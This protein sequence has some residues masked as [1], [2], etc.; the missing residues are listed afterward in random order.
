MARFSLAQVLIGATDQV[1][2]TYVVVQIVL[3]I[4]LLSQIVSPTHLFYGL[5]FLIHDV[6]LFMLPESIAVNV[7]HRSGVYRP[8]FRSLP[9]PTR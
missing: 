5:S 4:Q 6:N 2:D 3:G 8:V 1:H 7:N 9:E